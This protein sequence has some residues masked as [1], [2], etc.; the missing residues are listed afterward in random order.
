MLRDALVVL[1]T[2][3]HHLVLMVASCLSLEAIGADLKACSCV[4]ARLREE[5]SREWEAYPAVEA[6]GAW[7]QL[8]HP[9]TVK[10]LG[11]VLQRLSSSGKGAKL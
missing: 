3:V 6:A 10:V 7:A 1:D 4:Q 2:I 9:A 11:G 8:E 5:F